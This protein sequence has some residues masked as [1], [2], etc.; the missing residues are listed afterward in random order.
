MLN[1]VESVDC[2]MILLTLSNHLCSNLWPTACHSR[3]SQ[4]ARI[5]VLGAHDLVRT[6]SQAIGVVAWLAGVVVSLW[7]QNV[8][9][10]IAVVRDATTMRHMVLVVEHEDPAVSQDSTYY[11]LQ[12]CAQRKRKPVCLFAHRAMHI[13]RDSVCLTDIAHWPILARVEILATRKTLIRRIVPGAEKSVVGLGLAILPE[14]VVSLF[15]GVVVLRPHKKANILA[16]LGLKVSLQ[17]M[18]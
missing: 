13:C 6:C 17:V 12:N 3:R 14:V 16:N 10:G 2:R 5:R 7:L 18:I 8:I 4:K 1:F 15:V 9:Q 11:E